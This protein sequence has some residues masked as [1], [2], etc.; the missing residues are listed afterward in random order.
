MMA[1]LALVDALPELRDREK[2]LRALASAEGIGYE[3]ADY[4]GIRTQA[5]TTRILKYREDD[6]KV[7]ASKERAAGRTP[8]PIDEWRPIAPFGSSFHNYGAAFDVRIIKA[9]QGMTFVTALSRLGVLGGKA[10]LVWGG[11]WSDKRNDPPHFQLSTGLTQARERWEAMKKDGGAASILGSLTLP[12]VQVI[13]RNAPTA[14]TPHVIA[15]T[16][17]RHPVATATITTGALI[18]VALLTWVVVKRVTE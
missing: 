5:D 9:P 14:D 1:D 6:Y 18:A 3:I 13:G 4:G 2:K 12:G 16:I 17:Q 11:L 10:G 8:R 7:Y 15:A